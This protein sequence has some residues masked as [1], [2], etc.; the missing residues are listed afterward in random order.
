MRANPAA[1]RKGSADEAKRYVSLGRNLGIAAS[2][3][4]IK[5]QMGK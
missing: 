2:I 1:T 3:A 4:A 5:H